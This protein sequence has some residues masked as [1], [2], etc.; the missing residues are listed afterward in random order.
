M[1]KDILIISFME[2]INFEISSL[3]TSSYSN[4]STLSSVSSGSQHKILMPKP[5][6]RINEEK[7]YH[8]NKTNINLNKK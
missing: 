5:I 2:S 8:N 4:G 1:I 3:R 6:K 7:I